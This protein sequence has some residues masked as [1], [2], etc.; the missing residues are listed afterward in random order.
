[1]LSVLLRFTDSDYPFG[2]TVPKFLEC[3]RSGF[4]SR[5]DQ[6]SDHHIRI[7]CFSANNTVL[8]NENKN[9]LARNGDN[10]FE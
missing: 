9:W 10:A 8:S 6:T 1:V 4:E 7:Y 3:G 2:I 5:S